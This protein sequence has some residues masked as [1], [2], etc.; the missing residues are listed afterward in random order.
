[1]SLAEIVRAQLSCSVELP[2]GC[3]KTELI[4]QLVGSVAEE[5]QRVL[6]LTHTHAGVD[7]LRTRLHRRGIDFGSFRVATLDSWCFDLIRHYQILAGIEIADEPD[8]TRS[9]D[10]HEAGARA[11][12]AK[13]VNRMLQVSYDL[14]IVDEY[15][16]CQKWQH[17]LV[18]AIA[19]VL[20]TCVLGDRLQGLFFFGSN[21]PVRWVEDV[22]TS[23]P[24]VEVPVTAWR[25]A[26][27][28]AALG[29]WLLGIRPQLLNGSGVDL[30]AGPLTMIDSARVS[31]AC[32]SQPG[33]PERVVV[34]EPMEHQ[35]RQL[36][37]RLGGTYTMLEELEGRHL[38]D[39][40]RKISGQSPAV[41]AAEIIEFAVACAVGPATAFP[42]ASRKRLRAGTPLQPARFAGREKQV[43]ALNHVQKRV[44][45]TSIR[46]AMVQVSLIPEFK[47][48][49]REAWFGVLSALR[50]VETTGGLSLEQAITRERNQL[51]RIGRPPASRI[52]ARPLLIKGLEFDHAVVDQVAMYKAHELYVALT[53]AAKSL[54]VISDQPVVNPPLP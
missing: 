11:V 26:Q 10:Y 15:Q 2:A 48:H 22:A 14:L 23:F 21:D 47:L 1:M 12:V 35:C 39:F 45:A 20:P 24:A 13:A 6:V 49:R 28:N 16:D 52:L 9:R 18:K 8:W 54:T 50:L 7:A 5:S 51:R 3:G 17:E 37:M 46:Q 40:A 38:L 29:E 32:Y 33:H 36:A 44:D 25:W 34:I 41:V 43:E 53:R 42:A 4:A 31:S 27:S 19:E 30:A